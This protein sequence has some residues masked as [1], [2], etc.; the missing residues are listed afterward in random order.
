MVVCT[1]VESSHAPSREQRLLAC[2]RARLF[3]V[4]CA[5]RLVRGVFFVVRFEAAA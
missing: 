2:L 4:S 1:A 5:A 3:F